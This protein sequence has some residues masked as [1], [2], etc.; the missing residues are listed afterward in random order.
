MNVY[1]YNDAEASEILAEAE[2]FYGKRH[3]QIA[4][5]LSYIY[6]KATREGDSPKYR[7]AQNARF[8]G[9][10]DRYISVMYYFLSG[11]KANDQFEI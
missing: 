4:F 6:I 1:K 8:M 10:T 7:F 9:Y 2:G 3:M 5:T 11:I